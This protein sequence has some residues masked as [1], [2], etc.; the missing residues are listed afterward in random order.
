MT[1]VVSNHAISAADAATKA[2]T[3]GREYRR[4]AR[5]RTLISHRRFTGPFGL[6]FLG[7]SPNRHSR[8]VVVIRGRTHRSVRDRGAVGPRSCGLHLARHLD[9]DVLAT[10]RSDELDADRQ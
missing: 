2:A 10:V 6:A 7:M 5:W 9:Q 3:G 1:T 4:G 8:H